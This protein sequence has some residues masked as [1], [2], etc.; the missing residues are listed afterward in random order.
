MT[1]L[2]VIDANVIITLLA[3]EPTPKERELH[4]RWLNTRRTMEWAQAECDEIVVPAPVL[5]ELAHAD[6]QGQVILDAFIDAVGAQTR[7]EPFDQDAAQLA[8]EVLRTLIPKRKPGERKHP[9]KYDVM[10]SAI[11]H[12]IGAAHLITGDAKANSFPRHLEILQSPTKIIVSPD[13]PPGYQSEID[14]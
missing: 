4:R 11:A 13:L 2:A 7:I 5:A 8:G 12:R 10:I 6:K 3:D 1:K 14:I 9:M